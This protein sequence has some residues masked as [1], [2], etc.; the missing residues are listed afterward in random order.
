M[1]HVLQ[2]DGVRLIAF[3][4]SGHTSV[5]N[6]FMTS[7][8]GTVDRGPKPHDADTLRGDIKKAEKWPE[9][10]VTAAFIRHPLARIVSGW[11]HLNREH[12]YTP[13]KTYGFTPEM[14]FEQYVQRLLRVMASHNPEKVDPHFQPQHIGFRL[15]RGWLGSTQIM[16]LDEID[17]AWPQFVRTYQIECTLT[18][19]T[20]NKKSYPDGKSWTAMYVG[21]EPM[22]FKL[23]EHYQTDLYMW[24]RRQ[25]YGR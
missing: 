6:M 4:K 8:G 23:L 12:F 14:D 1:T 10:I 21:I 13:F 15:A 25:T 11:N 3:N 19:A 24:E 18:C 20:L 22:A 5:V 2:R 7:P 9:P 16:R 17:S